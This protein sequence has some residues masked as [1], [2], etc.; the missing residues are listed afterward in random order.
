MTTVQP[1]RVAAVVVAFNRADLLREALDA[2]A[3]QTRPLDEIVVVDNASTDD[4]ADVAATH[5]AGVRLVRLSRNTGGAGGFAV[6]LATA[7]AEPEVDF[8]WLMDDDT[9]PTPEALAE[10]LRVHSALGDAPPLLGSRVIW[11][12]GDDHPMNRPRRRPGFGPSP[13]ADAL[14]ALPVRSSSFVSMFVDARA[15]RATPLPVADYFIWN[16][17]FEYSL[18]LLKRRPGYFVA[19]SVVVHKTRVLGSTD[20]DPG[21]RF[22]YEVR[23][24]VWLLRRSTGLTGAERVLYAAASARRWLRTIAR[25]GDRR[26]LWRVGRRGWRDG[27]RTAPRSNAES[28]ADLGAVA[29]LVERHEQGV[30]A[31]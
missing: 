24:K 17:D 29:A 5:P 31:R 27:F 18:R 15:A 8:V 19:P 26:T 6:G 14:G 22:Y 30:A 4:S 23:N 21:E 12:N 10:L 25:S 9:I 11:T 1:P 7:L 20:T 2:L 16:D 28:L 13:E 3:A